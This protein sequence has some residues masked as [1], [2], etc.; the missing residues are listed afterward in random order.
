MALTQFRRFINY[1]RFVPAGS[2]VN[3]AI[4]RARTSFSS[5]DTRM[6]SSIGFLAWLM[7]WSESVLTSSS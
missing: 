6:I 1:D 2:F 3:L 7:S 4:L 5:L